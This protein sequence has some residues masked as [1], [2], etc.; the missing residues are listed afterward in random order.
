M[1]LGSQ[2]T[3][4]SAVAGLCV[5]TVIC[6]ANVYFG[7]QTGWISIM[8]MPASLMGFG[9][10]RTLRHH[11]RFPFT[12]AENVFLQSVACGMAVM[13]LGCGLVGLVSNYLP[14]I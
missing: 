11:L 4:R 1:S 5:G 10:F 2:F 13:P 7:L 9:I 3:L 6:A 14:E 8:S 12:P